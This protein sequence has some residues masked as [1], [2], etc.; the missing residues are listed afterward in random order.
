MEKHSLEIKES[1][2]RDGQV[3]KNINLKTRVNKAT[4]EVIPGIPVGKYIDVEKMFADGL[5]GVSG[6]GWQLMNIKAKYEGEDVSFSLMDN[7]R[8]DSEYKK[9]LAV[10]GVGDVVR[11]AAEQVKYTYKGQEKVKIDLSFSKVE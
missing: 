7:D 10:G 1:S 6:P 11:I 9:F 4:G 5:K 3:Y 8:D 2:G